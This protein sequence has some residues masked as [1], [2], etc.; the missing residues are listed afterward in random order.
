[1]AH[2]KIEKDILIEELVEEYPFSVEYLA[3]NGIRC[4][5]CGE[6]IWGTLK[7]A[8]EEKGFDDKKLEKFVV[9]L[10]ELNDKFEEKIQKEIN[11]INT[12]RTDV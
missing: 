5:V 12:G 3:K 6:P 9:E 7:E 2:L 10:N 4:I 11:K 8:S 1:M